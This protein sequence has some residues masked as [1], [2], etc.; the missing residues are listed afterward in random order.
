[1][2]TFKKVVARETLDVDASDLA[3]WL[4]SRGEDR[5][6]TVDGEP[7]L[8]GILSLPCTAR[9]LAEG[10]DQHRQGRLRLFAPM[11]SAPD[12]PQIDKYVDQEGGT[13]SF[14]VAWLLDGVA[15]Q[16]W[17]IAEDELAEEAE[18]LAT[19]HP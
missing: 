16:R 10:L 19:A 4:L 7:L 3:R 11:G 2:L 17:V 5:L 9:E 18:R 15:G 12:S 1:M 13:H 6:W 14:E 8:A